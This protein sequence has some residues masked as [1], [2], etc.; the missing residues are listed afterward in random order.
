VASP[1]A[2]GAIDDS[3]MAEFAAAVEGQKSGTLEPAPAAP[4]A[5]ENEK[6]LAEFENFNKKS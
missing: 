3:L 4:P 6:L 5:D 2:A 1:E